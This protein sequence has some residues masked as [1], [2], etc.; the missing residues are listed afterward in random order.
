LASSEAICGVTAEGSS[1]VLE[2]GAEAHPTKTQ[3]KK[4]PRNERMKLSSIVQ[5]ETSTGG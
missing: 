5:F 3:T 2:E 4:T 1:T